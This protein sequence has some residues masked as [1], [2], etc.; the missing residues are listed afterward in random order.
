MY[1]YI[2]HWNNRI[3]ERETEFVILLSSSLHEQLP[4]FDTYILNEFHANACIIHMDL[5]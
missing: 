5:C 1:V 4:I 2:F 3:E